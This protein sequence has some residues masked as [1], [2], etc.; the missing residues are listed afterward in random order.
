[1][2]AELEKFI[3]VYLNFEEAYDTS[4]YLR[5]TLYACSEAYSSAVR[6]GLASVLASRDLYVEDYEYLTGVEFGSEGKLYVYLQDMCDFL[7]DG[8]ERQPEPPE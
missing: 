3:R 4:G 2:N 5:P 7:F 6:E 8:A 1:M